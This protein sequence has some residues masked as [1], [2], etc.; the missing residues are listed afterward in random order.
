MRPP[1]R[2]VLWQQLAT[3]CVRT[4]GGG[5]RN[6]GVCERGTPPRAS[7]PPVQ[8]PQARAFA[9]DGR[10]RSTSSFA[11]AGTLP[12]RVCRGDSRPTW[13]CSPRSGHKID[14]AWGVIRSPRGSL[15]RRCACDPSGVVRWRARAPLAGRLRTSGEPLYTEGQDHQVDLLHP[16]R[17]AIRLLMDTAVQ[18]G[19]PAGACRQ[20]R[21]AAGPILKCPLVL[22]PKKARV[23][24]R[25]PGRPPVPAPAAV[26]DKICGTSNA[27]GH[28][29]LSTAVHNRPDSVRRYGRH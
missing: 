6:L 5:F 18:A 14:A 27:R 12:L 22:A 11:Y 13:V 10:T 24:A 4:Y 17:A 29:A 15:K 3:N 16:L 7:S 20:E 2:H 25:C 28:C 26:P 8:L 9:R 1:N 21:T 19:V 23:V